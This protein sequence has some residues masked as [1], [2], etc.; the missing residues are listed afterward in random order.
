MK[1]FSSK[2]RVAAAA[3][4]VVLLLFLLRPGASRLKSRIILSLSSALGRSVDIGSVQLRMLPRPGFDLESVVVYD[5]PQFG[6]EPMLRAGEV[7]ADLRLTSLLRGRFEIARLDLTEPSLNLVHGE[8]GRWNLEAL[9]ERSA[10]TPLAPTGKAKSEPRAG[11]PYIAGTS[12]RINFKSGLEKKPYSLTNADF[13]LWQESENTWG[14]RLKAQPMRSDL[15][16]N[17]LG[18][19]QINGTWQRAE[20]LRDTPLQ[21]SGEW[22]RAQLGQLT[23][24]LTGSDQGWRGGVQLDVALTG[25]PA[26][27]QAIA[28]VSLQD[29]QRYDITRGEALL[30][31]AH[32][33]AHYSTLDHMFRAVA[34]SAPVGNGALSLNGEAGLPGSHRYDLRLSAEKIPASALVAVVQRAKKNLPEDLSA[35]GTL[36]GSMVLEGV[37][38]GSSGPRVAG[39]G[40]ISEFRLASTAS[41]VAVG[42]E[43]LPFVISTGESSGR[44]SAAFRNSA[45]P[46]P[47]APHFEF[48]PLALGAGR[49]APVARGW[50]NGAGYN[51]SF[52]GETEV[53]SVL[54]L[55]QMVGLPVPQVAAEGNAQFDLKVA[56]AWAGWNYR[57]PGF[58]GPQVIGT[59]KLH[60]VRASIRGT[61]GPVEI[62]SADV[63]LL[64]DTVRVEKLNA[65]AADTSWSGSL[66][67]PRGCGAAGACLV[68]FNLNANQIGLHE[69]SGWVSP[70]PTERPWYRVLES[71][72]QARSSFLSSVRASGRITTDRLLVYKVAATRVSAKV[73]LDHGKVQISEL[74]ADVLGG[75]HRGAWDADFSASPGVCHGTGSL[76][77]VALE[78]FAEIMADTTR[79]RLASGTANASYDVKG[80][81]PAEFWGAAEGALQ[82]DIRDGSLAH[83]SLG[84]DEGPL[85]VAR[86]SGKALLH[87]GAFGIKTARLDSGGG[88]F[89]VSGMATLKGALDFKLSGRT[90]GPGY[91]ITGTLTAP[92]VAQVAKPETQARLKP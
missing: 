54:R 91:T 83:I 21:I 65:K 20:T 71:N 56:G 26:N 4:L 39:K 62:S 67:L 78:R 73:S 86:L 6:S 31:S 66:E 52:T 40:E 43:T 38:A 23:K 9:L 19:L 5:D 44:K 64:T 77:G 82:F 13:S 47:A 51:I 30:L 16:L 88:G 36:Q 14:V 58:V 15:N 42:P 2:R 61:A 63:E 1:P 92:R 17:D 27:L 34:C 37:G 57:G 90:N 3:A 48:G 46:F 72:P 55:A 84:E 76:L 24:F 89:D 11:F 22:S 8:N 60:N 87:S 7:T 80:T 74:N 45:P 35:G 41:Q 25:T 81:C 53:A 75:K 10:H 85:Q 50:I 70:Q 12:A 29:F 79:S 32:C 68:Q 18:I 49:A 59:A 28:N 69:L 33:D